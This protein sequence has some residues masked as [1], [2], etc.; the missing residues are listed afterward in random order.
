MCLTNI[1]LITS[2]VSLVSNS[3]TEVRGGTSGRAGAAL[4]KIGAGLDSVDAD[5]SIGHGP[6]PRGVPLPILHLR[7]REQ[8]FPTTNVFHAAPQPLP[9]D[10]AATS[11]AGLPFGGCPSNPNFRP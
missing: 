11:A 10:L 9:S 1:L 2:L 7:S 5:W 4:P 8:H 3:L 6:R